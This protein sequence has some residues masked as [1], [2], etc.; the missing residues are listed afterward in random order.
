MSVLKIPPEAADAQRRS[1]DPAAS[2][3]VSANAGA[4][5]TYILA[6]RVVRLLLAGVKPGAILCLTYTN[7]A[8]AEMATRVFR[9]LAELATLPEAELAQRVAALAPNVPTDEALVRARTLFALT[10]ET[11]GGLK[12]ETIH[13]FAANLLRRFPLEAQVSGA[14]RI[15]DDPTRAELTDRAIAAT[16]AEGATAP[17]GPVA[18]AIR[19]ALPHVAD[20]S[21]YDR[22]KAFLNARETLLD[23]L[24]AGAGTTRLKTSLREA[25]GVDATPLT[26]DFSDEHCRALAAALR[27]TGV[28]KSVD[29]AQQ[30]DDALAASDPDACDDILIAALLTRTGTAK[31]IGT[32]KVLASIPGIEDELAREQTRLEALKIRR[33]QEAV[34]EATV[35]LAQLA[36][37]ALSFVEAEKRRRGLIDYDDQIERARR[38]V[39]AS[40]AAA[41]VRYKL[42]E[43]ID[44]VML[45]EAQD[46]APAQ[47]QLVEA[48]TDEFFVGKGARE[49]LR[50]LF[51]VGDEKQSIYSFQGAAPKIF[52][53][54]RAYYGAR[55]EGAALPF[56]PV[57]LAHSFR[58][59]PQVLAAVDAVFARPDLAEAI[60]R[61]R[62]VRHVAVREITGGVDI[63]PLLG[64]DTIDV[65]EAWDAP[66]DTTP[67]S[68]GVAKLVSAIA[69]QIEA[70]REAGPDGG[71]PVDPGEVMILSR[72]RGT[73]AALM[74]RELKAR[75]IPAAGADRLD[76]T[77]HIAVK[78]MLALARALISRDDLSLAAVLRSPLF[79]FSDEALF[80]L[81]HGREGS[82]MAVLGEGD[83]T[84]KAA[85][86]TLSRW[87]TAALTRRPFDFLAGILIG[88]GRRA[89][90]AARMGSEAEDAL[91][92]FLDL[93]L[94]HEGQ[95]IPALEPF[96]MRLTKLSAEIRR[97]TEGGGG[98]V[99]VMTV[100]GAKGLEADVVFL[101]DI[102]SGSQRSRGNAI[103]PLEH[104]EDGAVLT[105]V[106]PKEDRPG[107]LAAVCDAREEADRHEHHR[108]LYVG[109]TRA[110]RHL[111]V[112]G[113]YGK[114][115]PSDTADTWHKAVLAGLA[116]A[117]EERPGGPLETYHAWRNPRA[118][119]SPAAGSAADEP[120]A[121]IEPPAWLYSPA[122]P[123]PVPPEPIVPSAAHEEPHAISV[124]GSRA[125][126]AAAY[127][128]L[129]HALV[130]R[131]GDHA[132][133]AA[134]ARRRYPALGEDEIAAIA[135]EAHAAL[136]LPELGGGG[137][138]SEI[139]LFG[140]VV[141]ENGTVRR[142][143]ARIDRIETGRETLIVDYKTD[144]EVP[145]DAAHAPSG[146]AR[147]L[148]IYRAL[149]SAILPGPVRTAI[150]W[151]HGPRFMMMDDALPDIRPA[152]ARA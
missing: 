82:L 119:P 115:A 70:W 69:D 22:L 16:L 148:A 137:V 30:L 78:D 97:T 84:A 35:P 116:E 123:L 131:G 32:A 114:Q 88:E 12:I 3:W 75:N 68:T 79:G 73:F 81:A 49:V 99:R 42:D 100:H 39:E 112:C 43:G 62:A 57:D 19:A 129:V 29:I 120:P 48:L 50:T 113:A 63:W 54:K 103:V 109:M 11:P 52:D 141:M 24:R 143:L 14:F 51:V 41:W 151:T 60:A 5:K 149:A 13:A 145:V 139:T 59:A 146:Y 121:P 9:Q 31:K 108:L 140:D 66:L 61:G 126:P 28:P 83:E 25:L 53:E 55:A 2:V 147:Q 65:P 150:V 136:T 44:H 117:A 98:K 76:V 125:L 4:G 86:R 6:Q 8:A 40:D 77:Q 47:W 91:D 56:D 152:P 105:V 94:D 45:D 74:N 127:G 23:W 21:L 132:A 133:L 130:E 95:G 33:R 138:H 106:P 111:V 67:A 89:D 107:P 128:S 18:A 93:A 90:F 118:D 20:A 104:G 27:E 96:L 7:A 142:A 122:P 36:Y 124:P 34:I 38:L 101:A 110:E 26:R 135:G 71:P 1:S 80:E 46:T 144:R 15:L 92:A 72:N 134:E 87:R 64:N 85:Q 17:A 58:S 37:R 102:G 10:L